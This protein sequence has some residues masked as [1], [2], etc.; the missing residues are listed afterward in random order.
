MQTPDPAD[1]SSTAGRPSTLEA[2]E[3]VI[4]LPEAGEPRS[5]R[6]Q[7]TFPPALEDD[8]TR[9]WALV[10]AVCL[11]L[12][13]LCLILSLPGQATPPAIRTTIHPLEAAGPGAVLGIPVPKRMRTHTVNAAGDQD[14]LSLAKGGP[15]SIARLIGAPVTGD[16]V[17]ERG[18]YD[19]NAFSVRS[20]G[21]AA[22]IVY[23]PYRGPT[24]VAATL[25]PQRR[26]TFEGTLQPVP[27]D[28]ASIVGVEAAA[29]AARTGAYIVA[30]P[31]SLHPVRH[32][33]RS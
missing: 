20:R 32:V 21:G 27:D 31:E 22:M 11:M 9:T 26:V 33:R 12:I 4:R 6:R 1:G 16:G 15:G 8:D 25:T 17:I 24:D 28:F 30:V 13:V 7:R 2:P 29:V 19:G 10:A 18:T 14:V 5:E 3:R 23:L